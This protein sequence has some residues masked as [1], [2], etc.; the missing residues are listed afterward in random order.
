MIP[1]PVSAGGPLC[2]L[3]VDDE[4]DIVA[5]LSTVLEDHGYS[6]VGARDTSTALRSLE[7]AVPDMILL[8]IMMP[9]HSG[10]SFYRELRRREETAR[11]PVLFIS[12]YSREEEFRKTALK[13]LAD[14]KLPAPDGYLEKPITV[15]QLLGRLG[16]ILER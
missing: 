15:P 4:E 11:V 9:G 3:V 12:G 5:Y 14:E 1:A 8:D 6:A 16:A 10:L 2:V 7:E 13:A